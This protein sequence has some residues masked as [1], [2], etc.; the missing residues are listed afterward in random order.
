MKQRLVMASVFLHEP[1]LLIVDEPMVGLDPRGARRLKSLLQKERD[2]RGLTVLLSTHTLGDAEE[3]CD[4]IL[5]I[6]QSY[7][8]ILAYKSSLI[9][10]YWPMDRLCRLSSYNFP[11]V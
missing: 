7:E 5:L 6:H 11:N 8:C 9:H 3:L 10:H 1:L 2:E 4:H